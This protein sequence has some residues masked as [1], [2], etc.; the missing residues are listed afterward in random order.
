M[1]GHVC[2]ARLTFTLP[3]LYLCCSLFCCRGSIVTRLISSWGWSSL[4]LLPI[5]TRFSVSLSLS[6]S[7]IARSQSAVL[8]GCDGAREMSDCSVSCHS[9]KDVMSSS[10]RGRCFGASLF[11]C[12]VPSCRTTHVD[13]ETCPM[14]ITR[15]RAKSKEHFFSGGITSIDDPIVINILYTIV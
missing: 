13:R 6:L 10:S 8:A 14:P 3:T 11:T 5:A 2:H 15:A 9:H 12:R 4:I 7:P 1:A